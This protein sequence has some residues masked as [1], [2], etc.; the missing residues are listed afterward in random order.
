MSAPTDFLRL[1]QELGIA[2]GSSIEEIKR[3]YR[4]RVSELH[5]DR[6]GNLLYAS[7]EEAAA[8]LQQITAHYNAALQF[9]RQHGRLP[10]SIVPPR[11]AALVEVAGPPPADTETAPATRSRMRVHVLIAILIAAVLAWLAWSDTSDAPGTDTPADIENAAETKAPEPVPAPVEEDVDV[12]V[13]E[14]PP[15]PPRELDI[16]MT[17]EEVSRIEDAPVVRDDGRWYYG[18]S[19][20]LFERGKVTDWYS[21]PLRPL[22]HATM[23]P[24][25]RKHAREP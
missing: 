20:I 18:P 22:R 14:S 25:P 13:A 24:E 12:P 17:V 2:P 8:R 23:H 21:S 3:A 9:H 4:R 19:W 15:P 1:Y 7:T 10:G 11:A 16:G 6:P 5:P